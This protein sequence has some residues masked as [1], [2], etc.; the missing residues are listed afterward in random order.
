MVSFYQNIR[1]FNDFKPYIE[2]SERRKIE[3]DLTV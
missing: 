2:S 1:F 3:L